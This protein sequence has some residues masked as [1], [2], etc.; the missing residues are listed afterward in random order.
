MTDKKKQRNKIE[1]PEEKN[2][3]LLKMWKKS[4]N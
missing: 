1:I 2:Q 3:L 4:K